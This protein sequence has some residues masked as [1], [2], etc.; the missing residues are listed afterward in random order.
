MIRRPPRSTRTDTLFPYTTL[1]RSLQAEHLLGV[2]ESQAVDLGGGIGEL[3]GRVGELLVEILVHGGLLR[4]VRQGLPVFVRFSINPGLL[5]FNITW[6][7][8]FLF[9][10]SSVWATPPPTPTP[11]SFTNPPPPAS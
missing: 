9:P 10:L 4:G 8:T 11:P 5:Q 1:F 3:A 7:S 2:L 6:G